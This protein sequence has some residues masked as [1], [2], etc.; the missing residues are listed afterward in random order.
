MTPVVTTDALDLH[1]HRVAPATDATRPPLLLL[2]GTGGDEHDLIELGHAVAPGA[3]LLS[4]RGNVREGDAPRFF[5]RLAEGVLDQDD[6]RRRAADLAA[7]VAAARERYGLAAPTAL[8]FSNGA[9]MA[10]ALLALHPGTLAGAVLLRPMVPLDP[11]PTT[12]P[13]PVD[14]AR[15]GTPVLIVSG[16]DDPLMR[17]GEAERLAVLLRQDGAAVAH[18]TVRAGHGLTGD[19][20]AIATAWLARRPFVS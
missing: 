8:G 13:R 1:R 12:V 14:A 6:V 7:F 15:P 2:H 10:A 17:P 16:T 18:H 19:D 11:W 3:A 5:R 4:V 20:V 9:N